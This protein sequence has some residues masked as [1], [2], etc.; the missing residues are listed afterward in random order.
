MYGT[1]GSSLTIT[2]NIADVCRPPQELWGTQ[3]AP[4]PLFIP[5]PLRRYVCYA[6]PCDKGPET[7]AAR[8]C[9]QSRAQSRKMDRY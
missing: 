9:S 4:T 2:V 3:R 5:Q 6:G 1:S 8:A 7:D